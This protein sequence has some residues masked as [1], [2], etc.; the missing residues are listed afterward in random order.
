MSTDDVFDYA[1]FHR[2]VEAALIADGLTVRREVVVNV[3]DGR[4]RRIDLLVSD[5]PEVAIEIDRITPR[6]GSL[7]KLQRFA[8]L[9]VIVLR[10]ARLPMPLVPGVDA[11][12]GLVPP[13]PTT[14]V[15]EALWQRVKFDRAARHFTGIVADD[16]A[17][18]GRAFPDVPIDV[19]IQRAEGWLV[20][21]TRRYRNF[22]KFLWNWFVKAERDA[23]GRG[24]LR[25]LPDPRRINDA[26]AGRRGGEAIIA[27]D[28]SITWAPGPWERSGEGP[29]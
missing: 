12:F 1:M 28:G 16:R 2:A 23:R 8:G 21:S 7:L 10:E 9:K 27:A 29:R 26:W 11:T 5:A 4:A 15:P 22:A 19:E 24:R 17:M 18:W 6:G 14:S 20:S 3:G 25:A 13:V